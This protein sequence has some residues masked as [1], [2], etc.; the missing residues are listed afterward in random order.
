[1]TP[2]PHTGRAGPVL[3]SNP[4]LSL[5]VPPLEDDVLPPSAVETSVL[6]LVLAS[7]PVE[8]SEVLSLSPVLDEHSVTPRSAMI[9]SICSMT[10]PVIAGTE[11]VSR[12]SAA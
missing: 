5:L 4:E 11:M 12:N 2:L 10:Q 6:V 7:V 3:L 9:A 8:A 1:M